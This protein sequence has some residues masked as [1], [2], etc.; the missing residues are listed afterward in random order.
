[1]KSKLFPFFLCQILGSLHSFNVSTIR[2]LHFS[3]MQTAKAASWGSLERPSHGNLVSSFRLFSCKTSFLKAPAQSP[4]PSCAH[5]VLS[6]DPPRLQKLII[7]GS[8]RHRTTKSFP[9]STYFHLASPPPRVTSLPVL[10]S[11]QMFLNPMPFLPHLQYS[12]PLQRAWRF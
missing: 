1:M 10:C 12:S 11:L 2:I 8:A 3:W 4:T 9:I 5:P 7:T 6:A